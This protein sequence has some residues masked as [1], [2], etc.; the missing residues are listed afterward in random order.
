MTTDTEMPSNIRLTSA[1]QENSSAPKSAGRRAGFEDPVRAMP[2]SSD[3][4]K[5]EG[6]S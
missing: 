1:Q 3:A 2:S 4:E 5:G 6:K